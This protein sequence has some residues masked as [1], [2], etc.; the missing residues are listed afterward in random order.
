MPFGVEHPPS[1]NL[2]FNK[3]PVSASVVLVVFQHHADSFNLMDAPLKQS[4][5]VILLMIQQLV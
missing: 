4:L 2:E 5:I 3:G 1:N